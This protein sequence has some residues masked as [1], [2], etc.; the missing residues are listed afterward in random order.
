MQV[1]KIYQGHCKDIL[2]QMPDEFVDMIITSPPYWGLRNYGDDT[3][4]HDPGDQA[5]QLLDTI[6]AKIQ[7][8]HLD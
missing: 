8:T 7:T 6:A 2:R 1:N 4:S 5:Y 3:A